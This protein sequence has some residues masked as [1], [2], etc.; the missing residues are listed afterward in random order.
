MTNRW[1]SLWVFCLCVWYFFSPLHFKLI[2]QF[3][4]G[5][6]KLSQRVAL[7][8]S[9]FQKSLPFWTGEGGEPQDILSLTHVCFRDLSRNAVVSVIIL[10][11][12]SAT[13]LHYIVSLEVTSQLRSV[14]EKDQS[15]I[16]QKFSYFAI[17]MVQSQNWL[18]ITSFC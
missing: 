14:L 17:R 7:K 4:S 8:F 15:R 5:I 9:T 11:L 18:K 12:T 6:A 1:R 3:L 13:E 10:F 16:K 2:Y